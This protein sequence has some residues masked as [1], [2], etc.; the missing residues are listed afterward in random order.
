MI[1][2]FLRRS[3]LV[4]TLCGVSA[5]MLSPL[6]AQAATTTLRGNVTYRERMALPPA[7]VE[8][9]LLDTS[10]ADAK[11]PVLARTS[12]RSTR[13]VPIPFSLQFDRALLK[14][15]HTYA[16]EATIFVEGRPWF[17]TTTQTPVP[18][19]AK[20]EIMLVLNRASASA[21][22]SPVGTWKAERLGDTPVTEGSR[23][24]LLTIAEDGTVSGFS[25]CNR[26]LS[27]ATLNGTQII[28]GPMITTRMA[29]LPQLMATEQLFL[30]NMEATRGW[31]L[32]PTGDV[33]ALVDAQDKPTVVFRRQA[34][35]NE[36]AATPA[37]TGTP[38][39][40]PAPAP[41]TPT[42]R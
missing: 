25:G 29:C 32:A 26:V 3:L 33:L 16:L 21:S 28:F 24:P 42:P 40:E 14:P 34:A 22:S 4:A 11:A 6:S 12:V 20:T 38:A 31:H 17:I 36:P 19:K 41:I 9:R 7:V 18:E 35:E 13:Q 23:P 1:P 5:A 27:K 2:S 30:K 39:A 10:Q 8:V 37:A 15:G